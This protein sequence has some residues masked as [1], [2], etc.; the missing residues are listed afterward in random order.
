MANQALR[1]AR[2]RAAGVVLAPP[3]KMRACTIGALPISRDDGSTAGGF[4]LF[5][6]ACAIPQTEKGGEE[7]MKKRIAAW[8]AFVGVSVGL[9]V[10]AS[11]ALAEDGVTKKY[12][13][14]HCKDPQIQQAVADNTGSQANHG[15]C[16][17]SL[18]AFLP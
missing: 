15:Q 1:T 10:G 3:Q 2:F 6:A 12:L 9:L 16:L 14:E 8:T 17:K 18:K 13:V 11:P 5:S 7:P 4:E